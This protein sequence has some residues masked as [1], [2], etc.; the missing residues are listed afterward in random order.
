M[1]IIFFP[2]MSV[3]IHLFVPTGERCVRVL[4]CV[5]FDCIHRAIRLT[6]ERYGAVACKKTRNRACVFFFR[7]RTSIFGR[8][9]KIR[10][11]QPVINTE[12]SPGSTISGSV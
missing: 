10:V 3:F 4:V 11:S 1:Q 6:D 5:F 12:R 8:P 2:V 7:Q 9:M